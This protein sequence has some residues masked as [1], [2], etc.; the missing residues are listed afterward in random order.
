MRPLIDFIHMAVCRNPVDL[1]YVRD[2]VQSPVI[3]YDKYPFHKF[4]ETAANNL[5]AAV[6]KIKG[7]AQ[8]EGRMPESYPVIVDLGG[9]KLNMAIGYS[10]CL[11]SSR[12]S[13]RGYAWLQTATRLSTAELFKLQGFTEKNMLDM[14]FVLPRGQLASMIGNAFTKTVITRVLKQA[15][16]AAESQ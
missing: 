14:E 6:V 3:N 12:C 1:K 10:P 11:T 15:V 16:K 5:R 13:A 7:I 9:S 4:S 8:A 2:I